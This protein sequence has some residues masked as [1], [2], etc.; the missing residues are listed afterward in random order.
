MY[1][2]REAL[3][4]Y[5]GQSRYNRGPQQHEKHC[6]KVSA[7][8][9]VIVLKYFFMTQ[10]VHAIISDYLGIGKE[11]S[12][13]QSIIKLRTKLRVITPT[14]VLYNIG[15]LIRDD[16]DFDYKLPDD[17]PDAVPLAN[18]AQRAAVRDAFVLQYFR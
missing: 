3:R 15:V 18:H 17:Q 6:R 8:F 5:R 1:E 12:F 13:R 2:D 10:F 16:I 14:A 4:T 7:Y 9:Q 11:G